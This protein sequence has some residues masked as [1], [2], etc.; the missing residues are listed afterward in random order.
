MKF[1]RL[2]RIVRFLVVGVLCLGGILVLVL[3]LS[4]GAENWPVAEEVAVV[5]GISRPDQPLFFTVTVKQQP[6]GSVLRE[7]QIYWV[8]GYRLEMRVGDGW[9]GIP[10]DQVSNWAFVSSSIGVKKSICRFDF[11]APAGEYR[12]LLL[13]RFR[14]GFD[15]MWRLVANRLPL[16]WRRT[17]NPLRPSGA[18][19]TENIVVG[20]GGSEE[21]TATI[22]E[23]D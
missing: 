18:I 4:P 7:E 13:Y 12:A 5:N 23:E 16:K 21:D 22:L 1:S 9:E 8:R 6:V 10:I 3:F 15:W 14:G 17:L 2:R 11:E 19:W 20:D